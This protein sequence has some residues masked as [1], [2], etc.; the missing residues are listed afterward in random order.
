MEGLGLRLSPTKVK[1][2]SQ[3][4]SIYG[5]GDIDVEKVY[6]NVM[7]K[8]KWGNFDK[9]KLFVDK[10]YMAEVQAMKLVMLRA[11][12]EFDRQG[13]KDKAAAMANKYFEAFPHMNFP[14]D[15]GIMPFINVLISAKDFE[16]AKKHLRILAEETKQYITF[17][18]SQTD[19]DVFDSFRQDYEY[20]LGAI[21]DVLD[22]AKK[23]EDPAFEKEMS[24]MLNPLLK[25]A[26][27]N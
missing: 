6:T 27:A 22:N 15:S 25:T 13:I 16:S 21:Q 9:M 14:Y 12:I 10:S 2:K 26:P 3:L 24:D 17:Y 1:V 20:R 7:T 5:F 11:A 19:K 23:V 18:E 8:W 4:P